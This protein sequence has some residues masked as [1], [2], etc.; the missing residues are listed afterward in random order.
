[1]RSPVRWFLWLAFAGWAGTLYF[2]SSQST[3]PVAIPRFPHVD[4]VLHFSYFAVGG[5]ILGFAVALTFPWTARVRNG[6]ALLVLVGVG[7]LDEWHQ[8]CTPS[9]SGNDL[10][11]FTADSL[12]ALTGILVASWLYGWIR[13]LCKEPDRTGSLN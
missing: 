8:T 4:K 1:M 12:G 10:W 3:Y 9:R 7:L 5:A 11:D 6:L 2:L 13:G